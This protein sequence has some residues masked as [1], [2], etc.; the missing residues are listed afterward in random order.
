MWALLVLRN[1]PVAL[2]QPNQAK[3][4]YLPGPLDVPSSDCCPV[5]VSQAKP[6]LAWSWVPFGDW[7]EVLRLWI[8]QQR[9]GSEQAQFCFPPGAR[10]TV[11]GC[12]HKPGCPRD[13]QQSEAIPV[14]G[15]G[16]PCLN[17]LYLHYPRTSH[18]SCA[19]CSRSSSEDFL[20][21]ILLVNSSHLP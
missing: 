9:G 3:G 1:G 5:L 10:G 16:E 21:K 7:W 12:G 18:L 4:A 8:S 20:L 15:Q 19:T 11:H 14:P 6:I 13:L 2:L 17:L